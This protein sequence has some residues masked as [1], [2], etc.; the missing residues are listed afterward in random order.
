VKDS[1]SFISM[2]RSA[3]SAI[4]IHAA[5]AVEVSVYAT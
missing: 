4:A 5:V 1:H 3:Q 2:Q